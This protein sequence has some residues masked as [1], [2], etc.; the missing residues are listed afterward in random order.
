MLNLQEGHATK[1]E[2][3]GRAMI[4]SQA[5]GQIMKTVMTTVKPSSESLDMMCQKD[6]DHVMLATIE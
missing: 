3:A 6:V 2:V 1:T 5:S 4:V